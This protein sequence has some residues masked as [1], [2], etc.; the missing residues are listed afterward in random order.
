MNVFPDFDGLGGIGD[1]KEVIGALLTFVLVIAVLMLIVSAIVWAVAS[2]H[3]NHATASKS[4]TGLLVALGT[5]ALAG[6][7]VAWM[8]WL[9]AVGD[10]L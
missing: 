3:G 4:R 10:Q 2:A 8:N 9:I 5:A 7:G 6:G 1:L